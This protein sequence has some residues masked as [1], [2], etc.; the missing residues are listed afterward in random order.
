MKKRIVPVI[1]ILLFATLVVIFISGKFLYKPESAMVQPKVVVP[2][3]DSSSKKEDSETTLLSEDAALVSLIKLNQDETLISIV[4]MDFDGDGFEDQV[5]AIK[6]NTSPY[7]SLLIGLYNPKNSLY[8]RMGV[9][10]TKIIQTKTFA[11]TGM[12]ITGEHKISLVYQGYAENGNSILQAYFISKQGGRIRLNQIANFEGDGTIFI[13]QLDRYDEYDKTNTPGQS[14]PIWVYTSDTAQSDAV[15]TDQLQIK[16]DWNSEAKK[17]IKVLQVRV[18]GNKIAEKELA[19]IQDGTEKTFANFLEGLWY[20]TDN[21]G[22]DIRYLSYNYDSREIIFLDS[23][24]E[25][26]YSWENTNLRRNG[27]YLSATNQEIQN[28]QRRINISLRSIDTINIKIQDDV[29]MLI[30]E[31][32]LWDGEYKKLNTNASFSN[33]KTK[34]NLSE[35]YKTELEKGPIWKTSDGSIITFGYG[36]YTATGSSISETG[37]FVFEN[38][39]GKQFIQ[40]RSDKEDSL[41]SGMYCVSYSKQKS[42]STLQPKGK[43][44]N[45]AEAIQYNKNSIILVPYKLTPEGSYPLEGH[46]IILTRSTNE[47]Q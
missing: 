4:S 43:S 46:T 10:A 41:F 18:P 27:A 16:Y 26:V 8:E 30:N 19:R 2:Q 6:T 35:D 3:A 24:T 1:F 34:Q 39:D 17:Y 11:Y 5:N 44:K 42:D 45:A 47:Q 28:L 36:S 13:Q 21:E 23:D 33:Q 40:F 15:N 14:F 22:A 12:D 31:G 20:K 29:R 37:K 32:N 9:I 38:A 7:I 25:E